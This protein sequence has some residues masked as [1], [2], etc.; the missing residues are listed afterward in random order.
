M[1]IQDMLGDLGD[2]P[3]IKTSADIIF[4]LDSSNPYDYEE[5]IFSFVEKLCFDFEKISHKPDKIRMDIVWHNTNENSV[6]FDRMGFT[7]I[8]E[9]TSVIQ[10]YFRDLGT[11]KHNKN[12]TAMKAL[13]EALRSKWNCDGDRLRHI[14]VLITDHSDPIDK[15]HL[16]D[17][18]LDWDSAKCLGSQPGDD[19]WG[20][21]TWLDKRGKRLILVAPDEFPYDEMGVELDYVIRIDNKSVSK[22]D[23]WENVIDY[24]LYAVK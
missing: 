6:F 17:F 14:I 15:E 1:N 2:F 16:M 8:T 21:Y 11:K 5:V 13:D 23:S 9:D 4:V 10:T 7:E 22:K 18:Y 20:R 3:E 12:V 19:G 24:C